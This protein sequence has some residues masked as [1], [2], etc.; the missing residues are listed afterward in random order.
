[1]TSMWIQRRERSGGNRTCRAEAHRPLSGETQQSGENV[2]QRLR[3][4]D[5]AGMCLSCATCL[6]P[7]AACSCWRFETIG[8]LVW[9]HHTMDRKC[10]N[11]NTQ[12]DVCELSRLHMDVRL[13]HI[14]SPPC[15]GWLCERRQGVCRSHCKG[16]FA[17]AIRSKVRHLVRQSTMI[18]DC[19]L[20]CQSPDVLAIGHVSTRQ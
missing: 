17:P 7:R 1:M 14:D 9:V 3:M 18:I 8:M 15:E 2:I 20:S 11:M 16:A 12:T 4:I 19:M 5:M 6:T 10:F 13:C